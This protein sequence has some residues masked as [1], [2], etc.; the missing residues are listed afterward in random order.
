MSDPWREWFAKNCSSWNDVEDVD[1]ELY[2]MRGYGYDPEADS[3][4]CGNCR[5]HHIDHGE[6]GR[7]PEDE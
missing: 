6:H 5:R 1:A 7:C 3:E 4:I 2:R